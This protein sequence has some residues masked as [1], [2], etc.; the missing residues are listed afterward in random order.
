ME[1]YHRQDVAAACIFLATKT[2]ECGRKL[3]DVARVFSAKVGNKEM[4][5]IAMDSKELEQIQNTILATEEAL[6]ETLCFEFWVES[7]HVQL[8]QLL[9][10]YASPPPALQDY[11][12]SIAHDSFRT[13]LSVLYSARVIASACFI[14]AQKHHE[15]PNSVSLDAR[16][17]T[18]APSATLPT[19]PSRHSIPLLPSHDRSRFVVDYL[20]LSEDE[21]ACVADALCILIEY[22]SAQDNAP[23]VA[24]LGLVQ[25]PTISPTRSKLY[26]PFNQ[27]HM[28]KEAPNTTVTAANL[29][30][31]SSHGGSN[32]PAHALTGH[33]DLS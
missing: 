18:P 24:N 15:G 2:E 17:S 13:P 23:H 21:L 10:A 9:Q 7:P 6:L 26:R 4:S 22:Y 14:L 33:L 8:I 20:T 29:T 16:I 27:L 31:D 25:L 5:E 11:A 1:D 32:T 12:W 19:P 30:P 28:P 3:R